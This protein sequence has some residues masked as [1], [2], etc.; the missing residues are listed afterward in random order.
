MNST[1][2][3]QIKRIGNLIRYEWMSRKR[4]YLLA[5]TG[6]IA[7][8]IFFF[9]VFFL[10]NL[11]SMRWESEYYH[12]VYILGFIVLAWGIVGQS[13]LDLRENKS[14][15]LYLRL[16]ASHFEKFSVQCL[17]RVV[18]PIISYPLIFW[19]ASV[20]SVYLFELADL[21]FAFSGEIG[22]PE[23]FRFSSFIVS[24]A[25]NNPVV[26]LLILGMACLIPS[27]MFVGGIIFG[28]RNLVL[29]PISILT[30]YLLITASSLL[31]AWIVFPDSL[32]W[33]EQ[34]AFNFPN[35]DQPEIS[36]D[37]PILIFACMILIWMGVF[38]SYVVSYFKLTEREV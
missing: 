17:L 35:I 21:I 14:A 4:V 9:Q 12:A 13:F 2:N 28:K 20:L 27:L 37:V 5:V 25:V 26:S 11:G 30:F 36:P 18:L 3:F 19:L 34:V 24:N 8:H 10:S 6:L 23:V 7:L 38:L 31:L 33:S 32:V 22:S 29:M 15:S 1:S 16:P